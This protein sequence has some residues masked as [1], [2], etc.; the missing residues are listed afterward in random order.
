MTILEVK[1]QFT[2]MVTDR[3]HLTKS[4]KNF[5]EKLSMD[6]TCHKMSQ[7]SVFF[8][9]NLEAVPSPPVPSCY[10]SLALQIPFEKVFRHQKPT[11]KPLAEGIGA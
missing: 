10:F 7:K 6:S 4:T 3:H 2:A 9:L 11:P 8:Y 1:K 5:I